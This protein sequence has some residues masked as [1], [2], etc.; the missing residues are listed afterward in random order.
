MKESSVA[1]GV[2]RKGEDDYQNSIE[3]IGDKD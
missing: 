1:C 2:A 3:W